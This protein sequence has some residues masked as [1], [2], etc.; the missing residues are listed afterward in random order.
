MLGPVFTPV[1]L[2]IDALTTVSGTPVT[3]KNKK[4][5]EKEQH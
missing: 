3:F 2:S 4:K 5:S 1:L